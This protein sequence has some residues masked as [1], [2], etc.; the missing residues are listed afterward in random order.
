MKENE[1]LTEEEKEI[2]QKF[3][4]ESLEKFAEN[5]KEIIE[6]LKKASTKEEANK[7]YKENIEDMMLS[8]ES[9]GD[10]NRAILDLHT[11]ELDTKSG[12]YYSNGINENAL[13]EEDEEIVNKFLKNYGLRILYD[14]VSHRL[15]V[16][17]NF[18]YDI[19]KDYVT[20]EYKEYL[21][22]EVKEKEK[23]H[24]SKG[25][26]LITFE[27]LGER[28]VAWEKFLEKY[29]NSTLKSKV[30]YICG[31]QKEAYIFGLHYTPT[32]IISDD[33][34]SYKIAEESMKA[35]DIFIKKYPDSP[36]T[37]VI[38]YFLEN[39]ENEDIAIEV[40]EKIYSLQDLD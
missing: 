17:P 10:K 18:Y 24:S 40:H 37:E 30:E 28:I 39:Y 32:L 25:A 31:I 16:V 15:D 34:K 9:L 4:K 29:P 19:F 26:M 2:I 21:K 14:D 7:I 36:T 12:I 11:Y 35:F 8:V 20:E 13:K 33:G 3:D 6:K 27:E 38:K 1:E 23:S 5:K 22:L